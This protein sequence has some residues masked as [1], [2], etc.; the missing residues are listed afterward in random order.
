MR[1]LVYLNLSLIL[2]ALFLKHDYCVGNLSIEF[3]L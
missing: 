2:D 1:V 3:H